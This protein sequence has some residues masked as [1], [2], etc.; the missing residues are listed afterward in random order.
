MPDRHRCKC[1]TEDCEHTALH[2][3]EL[4]HGDNHWSIPPAVLQ[5][6]N[7]I[8]AVR[9]RYARGEEHER[10]ALAALLYRQGCL[11]LQSGAPEHARACWEEA[12]A[13]CGETVSARQRVAIAAD[14]GRLLLTMLDRSAINMLDR[15]IALLRAEP[16]Q[17]GEL[18][19]VLAARA[20][21]AQHDGDLLAAIAGLSEAAALL[22]A[23][24]GQTR[25]PRDAAALGHALLDLGRA[26]LATG[27]VAQARESFAN[28][29]ELAEA[30]NAADPTQA[31][32]NILNA[33]LNHLGRTEEAS[34]R[35]ERA[36]PLYER[37]ALDM[38]RL[39]DEGRADLADDLAQAEADLAR[40][41]AAV[42]TH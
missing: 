40:A 13:A 30:L 35:P 21:A 31:A 29:V 32:R 4:L 14:L 27:G 1:E 24:L 34:G 18:A 28:S 2:E 9:A 33:A 17:R 22:E 15:A 19:S 41:R 36:L 16:D 25:S 39:V 37:S 6:Q 7:E 38:R 12:Y 10:G 26:H 42:T 3:H 11:A 20:S 8:G 23:H 5:L